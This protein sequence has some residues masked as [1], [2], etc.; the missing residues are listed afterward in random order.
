MTAPTNTAA[1]SIS[2]TAQVGQTLTASPGTWTSGVTPT[3]AYQ[4]RTCD[5]GGSGCADIAGATSP[6]YTPVTGDAGSTIKVNVSATN[7]GG[8]TGPVAS[9]QTA[10]VAAAATSG[11]GGGGG[12]GSGGG[13]SNGGGGGSSGGTSAPTNP[14]PVIATP[15]TAPTTTTQAPFTPVRTLTTHEVVVPKTVVLAAAL[16]HGK[17]GKLRV[18]L[19]TGSGKT[20]VTATIKHKASLIAKVR[21]RFSNMKTGKTYTLPWKPPTTL[22]GA[23]TVCMVA[24]N[25]VGKSGKAACAPATVL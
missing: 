6:T 17:T 15:V 19:T 7:A 12:G 13:G 8:T 23:I 2:G 25:S 20:L 18:K 21:S 22:R 14:A 11:G 9:T 16:T 5:S 10:T 4:W 24:T 1:P 3:Y